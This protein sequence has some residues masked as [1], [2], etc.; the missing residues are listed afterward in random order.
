LYRNG[1]LIFSSIPM[2]APRSDKSSSVPIEV[3]EVA[4][5]ASSLRDPRSESFCLKA[6]SRCRGLRHVASRDVGAGWEVG[7]FQANWSPVRIEKMRG[8]R[9]LKSRSES[10]GAETDNHLFSSLR[11]NHS[12]DE[13]TRSFDEPGGWSSSAPF[14]H[15]EMGRVC[16]L[17]ND[18]CNSIGSVD[19]C[20]RPPSTITPFARACGIKGAAVVLEQK[21]FCQK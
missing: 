7:H 20:D 17:E 19:G 15:W 3:A 4:V 14:R 16:D 10:I 1:A 18:R 13:N 21:E 6:N 8:N 5:G 9:N 12:S 2:S 11:L